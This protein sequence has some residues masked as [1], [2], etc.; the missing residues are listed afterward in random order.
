MS[1]NYVV[2]DTATGIILRAGTCPLEMVSVQAE[3]GQGVAASEMG[4]LKI[5][6]LT[7]G[8]KLFSSIDD[9]EWLTI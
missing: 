2:Y 6:A 5:H 3:D 1:V 8:T 9:V 7:S 4:A